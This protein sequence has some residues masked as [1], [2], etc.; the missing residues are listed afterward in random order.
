MATVVFIIAVLIALLL[1]GYI[2][3]HPQAIIE[4]QKQFYALINWRME[5]ISMSKEIRNTKLMGAFLI[6]FVLI[7]CIYY[8]LR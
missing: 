4:I 2:Y 7:S 6:I 1:G 8:W 3:T 5:P